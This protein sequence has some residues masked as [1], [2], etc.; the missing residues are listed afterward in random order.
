MLQKNEK[1]KAH[2]LRL[3]KN[4]WVVGMVGFKNVKHEKCKAL[5]VITKSS[6]FWYLVFEAY[7]EN[8]SSEKL[9]GGSQFV[10]SIKIFVNIG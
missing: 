4:D 3:K 2:H 10:I 6:F 5:K 9:Y 8:Y 7:N 1:Y